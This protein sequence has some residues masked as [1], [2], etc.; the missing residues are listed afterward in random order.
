[1]GL[2]SRKSASKEERGP[3]APEYNV[4]QAQREAMNQ[5]THFGPSS[6]PPLDG[7]REQPLLHASQR[8]RNTSH[9]VMS[10]PS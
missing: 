5:P 3:E 6:G 8:R 4:R 2:F 10:F 1:M 9:I 7:H